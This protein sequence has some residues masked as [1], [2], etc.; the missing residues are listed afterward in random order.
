[1]GEDGP[2]AGPSWSGHAEAAPR[3]V[4]VRTTTDVPGT[5][6]TKVPAPPIVG[7]KAWGAD[8]SIRSNERQFSPIRKLIVHHTASDNRPANPA[9]VV[10][11]TYRYHV[12]GRGFSDMGYNYMIDHRGVIYEGRYARP[13]TKEP[14]TGEDRNGW[15]VVGAHA[16]HMNHGSCGVCLIGNF[17]LGAPTDAALTSLTWL[18]AWKAGRNRIN[19]LAEDVFENVYAQFFD[20]R[21]LSGHR[22]VGFTLC[23]GSRLYAQ[24]PSIRQAAAS[25]A[26]AFDPLIVDIPAMVRSEHGAGEGPT[27]TS[28]STTSTT[29]TST[30]TSTSTTSTTTSPSSSPAASSPGSTPAPASTST[31]SAGAATGSKPTGYRAVTSSGLL[32]NTKNAAGHG[33]PGADVVGLASPGAGDGYA[34]VAASG[35]VFT[36]GSVVAKGDATGKGTAVDIAT[37]R[38]GQGYW[39]LM[40]DGGIYPFGDAKYFGSPKRSRARMTAAA[41]E[42]RPAGDG[43]WVLGADGTVT[44]FGAAKSFGRAA[45]S[46]TAVDLAVTP[47]GTGC[48]VLFDSGTVS[49]FGDAVAAGD[50]T[51]VKTRWNKPAT[52]ITALPA[53]K[54]YV[55]SARDGGLFTFGG[56]PFFGT[57]A[58][59]GATV[60]GLAVAC[61]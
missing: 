48:F 57:F 25:Q 34:A 23:P 46:G 59:S 15:G 5:N 26:G 1:M 32:L 11:Q 6:A 55:L 28:T 8:E 41:I 27:T 4:A 60:V 42:P 56:A 9:A 53:S 49:V 38:S 13:Y 58:G 20:F 3:A 30:S 54:G 61:A 43:Y 19:L 21:N 50:L 17:E 10:R 37:T 31:T 7:R 40:S 33:K 51:T 24:L 18:L 47:T 45:A 14:I 22:N 16:K 12:L 35:K 52:A 44:G 36:F 39:V 2:T 29:S